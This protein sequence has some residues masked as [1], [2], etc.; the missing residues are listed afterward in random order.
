MTSPLSCPCPAAWTFCSSARRSDLGDLRSA[1]AAHG[2]QDRAVVEVGEE[3]APRRGL[4]ANARRGR[5]SP[6]G[7]PVRQRHLDEA[8]KTARGTSEEST[9]SVRLVEPTAIIREKSSRPSSLSQSAATSRARGL[10]RLRGRQQVLERQRVGLVEEEHALALLLRDGQD[11]LQQLAGVRAELGGQV[12][13]LEVVEDRARLGGE[14]AGQ[15]RLA[16]AGRAVEQHALGRRDAPLAVELGV[17]EGRRE[18]PHDALGLGR[19]PIWSNVV[20][21]LIRTTTRP[22]RSPNF[23]P[24]LAKTS[25]M[26][27]WIAH[28][29]PSSSGADGAG[30]S[31]AGRFSRLVGQRASPAPRLA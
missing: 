24:S 6:A 5:G 7:R 20:S 11:L 26:R 16:R 27:R 1:H 31:A 10:P 28:S 17:R 22:E 15:H 8:I 18:A 13:Q 30:P 25:S 2:R 29:W 4:G 23:S 12:H 21:G 19:P 14:R 3:R 9:E